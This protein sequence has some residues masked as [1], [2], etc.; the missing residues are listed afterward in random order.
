MVLARAEAGDP[1]VSP[2]RS[3]APPEALAC[4]ERVF[5]RERAPTELRLAA[6]EAA[7]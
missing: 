7:S 1:E 5:A 3:S 6:A 4:A 2:S